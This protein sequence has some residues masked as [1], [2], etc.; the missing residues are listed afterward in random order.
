[1]AT[2]PIGNASDKPET[3][4]T[5][6]FSLRFGTDISVVFA[7]IAPHTLDNI[8]F[9]SVDFAVEEKWRNQTIYPL[10]LV[11]C[12]FPREYL[13]LCPVHQVWSL[14][15]PLP[16]TQSAY[17]QRPTNIDSDTHKHSRLF[18]VVPAIQHILSPTQ[19]L[20]ILC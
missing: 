9:R 18:T 7:F 4:L 11:K 1:M 12:V 6:V 15:R 3:K 13:D 2:S 20:S 17:F 5:P 14:Q 10:S 8:L 19:I 16:K